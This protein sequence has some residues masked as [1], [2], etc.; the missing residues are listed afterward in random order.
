[1]APVDTRDARGNTPLMWAYM[2]G[3]GEELV[4]LLLA[5]QADPEAR[6]KSGHCLTA[7]MLTNPS[8]LPRPDGTSSEASQAKGEDPSG[9]Y[10]HQRSSN[11]SVEAGSQLGTPYTL[12][13]ANSVKVDEK[14]S[15]WSNTLKILKSPVRDSTGFMKQVEAHE[16]ADL[17][18]EERDAGVWSDFVMN[19]THAGL[20]AAVEPRTQD[21]EPTN[22]WNG[23]QVLVV[24]L[25]RILLFNARS[26]TLSHVVS[27]S[28]LAELSFSA[29]CPEVLIVR[30]FRSPDLVLDLPA[31][32]RSRLIEELQL[33]T[34][35]VNARWGGTDFGGGLQIIQECEPIS[36]L[37]DALRQ[38][39]GLLAWVEIGTFLMLPFRANSALLA[40]RDVFFFG[41]LDLHQ[42][43]KTWAWNKFFFVL[44]SSVGEDRKLM[45]S[46]HPNDE[47]PVGAI[48]V[49]DIKAVQ[50]LDNPSGEVCLI[51]D[52]T[53]AAGCPD[54]LTLRA[55]SLQS[56]EDWIVSIRTMQNG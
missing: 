38:K 36:E 1:M 30:P 17:S 2:G 29:H 42:G 46:R 48:H 26:W 47:H 50:A 44:K 25:E 13:K 39:V 35:Q 18:P 33:A 34:H 24:T 21:E 11:S 8:A 14:S 55:S 54:L 5:A 20:T 10:G 51:V 15:F 28:E 43:G 4:P 12:I 37:Y 7:A 56:R 23:R 41:T 53:N 27:L 3:K 6:N 9:A 31:A 40:G 19:Y 16:Q 32:S 45:W 22:R 52:Y 49:H